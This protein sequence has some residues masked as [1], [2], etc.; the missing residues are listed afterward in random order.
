MKVCSVEKAIEH[1]YMGWITET[2][3][4]SSFCKIWGLEDKMPRNES[5]NKIWIFAQ[6]W[7]QIFFI[8][9]TKKNTFGYF[10]S[11]ILKFPT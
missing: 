5:Q 3:T 2:H 7:N 1:T 11:Q 6:I 9:L 10:K 8:S 4:G